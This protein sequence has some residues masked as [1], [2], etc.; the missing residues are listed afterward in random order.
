MSIAELQLWI[1]QK[2]W[3]AFGGAVVLSLVG[4]FI[5]RSI[6]ARG[7]IYL[8]GRT[9]TKYDDIIVNNLRPFRVAWLAP[10]L[11]LYFFAYLLPDF[12]LVIEKATLF[13]ILWV[14]AFTLSSLLNALN[15][16]HESSPT[17]TGVS[18]QGYLDIIKILVILVGIILSVSLFTEES[19]VV[20]L[21]GL[22]ALTAVLLLVFRDTILSLV[23][24]IQIAAHDLIKEGDW[25]EVPSYG[26]DGDV[27]NMSLHTVKIQNF[28]K[29]I[30]VI[31]THKI[32][33][34]AYRNWRGMQES[35]GRRIKRSIHVDLTTIKFC[36]QEMIERFRDIDLARGYLDSKLMEIEQYSA[37]RG[38]AGGNPLNGRRLTNVG[39][40]Q[41]YVAAYLHSC[42]EIHEGMTFVVRQLAP[43]PTG[44][45]LEIYA[46]TKTVVWPE[47]EAIQADIFDHLL[48]AAA[49]FDLRVFQQPTG[50]DFKEFANALGTQGGAA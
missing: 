14:V 49:Y 16:I 12:Q 39:V 11:V 25:L 46:F 31:P 50:Q 32:M 7:L 45:P 27:I 10:L 20:L 43:G 13:L 44:L 3:L 47:Y 18:I 29:T 40:F 17:F 35:G 42:E 28:D 33:E 4:F 2:P 37:D 21:S 24:S 9:E 8:A 38:G 19:P 15:Q 26:A 5:A 41:A 6:I 36:D 22:G 30:T 1:E 23:A 34:V 48:A